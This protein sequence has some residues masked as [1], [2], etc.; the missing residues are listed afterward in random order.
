MKWRAI[1][2]VVLVVA[3]VLGGLTYYYRQDLI[4]NI[5]EPTSS[6]VESGEIETGN[7]EVIAD[8]LT[9]PWSIAHLPEGDMLVSQR[10]GQLKRL[11]PGGAVYEIA[12][13]RETSE[14]GLLGVTLHPDF[15]SNQLIYLYYTTDNGSGLSNQVVSA[16]LADDRLGEQ[17]TI[18]DNIPAAT[19]HN[20]GAIAFGPDSKLYITTGD[21][22]TAQLAQDRQSLAGK[23]LRLNPDGSIPADNPYGNAVWSYGHRNPQGI[24]WDSDGRLWSVEHGPSGRDE[25]NLIEEGENYGWPEI[26]G[27]E[28]K[29][30]MRSPVVQS[31][32]NDTWAPA[33][34]VFADGK[35]YFTGLRGQALYEVSSIDSQP[36]LRQYLQAEYGRLRAIT[37]RDSA[38]YV[39][40]SNRD[41]R[42]SP[43]FG[44][45]KILRIPLDLVD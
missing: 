26:S 39:G 9:T 19:N 36:Q 6:S 2:V 30:G 35:L 11:S 3:L 34:M 31:G 28:T 27:D 15:A 29:D 5:F 41:G 37:S 10:S 21:A 24:A 12:G 23:I 16:E 13:V 14:G 38:L 17:Q 25:V 8:D 43:S 40:T 20:G 4:A 33:Q 44:N 32:D 1:G 42:G 22:A 45:D 18:I 7:I